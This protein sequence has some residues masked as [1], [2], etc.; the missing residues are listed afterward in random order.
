MR[1][2]QKEWPKE[3]T[4]DDI[5]GRDIIGLMGEVIQPEV[6]NGGAGGPEVARGVKH[7]TRSQATQ[8]G[9]APEVYTPT[10]A[11]VSAHCLILPEAKSILCVET[12]HNI[13]CIF[14]VKLSS[15]AGNLATVPEVSTQSRSNNSSIN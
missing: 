9:R 10:A 11:V 5:R 2:R 12:Y 8:L 14:G 15:I 3:I 13:D 7:V 1:Q 4:I 6:D